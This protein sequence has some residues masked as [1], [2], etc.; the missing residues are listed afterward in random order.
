MKDR[1]SNPFD[2]NFS[3]PAT[4][5]KKKVASCVFPLIASLS[6]LFGRSSSINRPNASNGDMTVGDSRDCH[7]FRH[8]VNDSFSAGTSGNRIWHSFA[9]CMV[10]NT[11]ELNQHHFPC[12]FKSPILTFR[13]I[14]ITAKEKDSIIVRI[15]LQCGNHSK[16]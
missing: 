12:G 2:S 4:A 9:R 13:P 6:V 16:N 8:D 15:Y 1:N 10:P 14:L 5:W 3:S 7:T 11:E